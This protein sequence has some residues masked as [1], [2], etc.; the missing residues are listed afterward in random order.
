[1][2]QG[3]EDFFIQDE[4]FLMRMEVIRIDL[5]GGKGDT[6]VLFSGKERI[7]CIY[8]E[9]TTSMHGGSVFGRWIGICIRVALL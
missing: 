8:P 7:L 5:N 9:D 4:N 3:E 2:L 6:S 1:M